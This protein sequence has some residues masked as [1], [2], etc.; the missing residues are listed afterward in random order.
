MQVTG[1]VRKRARLG[2]TLIEL[3]VVVAIIALLISILLPS[4]SKAREQARTTLCM[5]RIA[6]LNKAM[7]LYDADFAT[8]P[9]VGIG[10]ED[11]GQSKTWFGEDSMEYWA[12]NENWLFETGVMRQ[13][14]LS[15]EEDW[16]DI[17]GGRAQVR[18]GAL[19]PYTRFEELYRC[20]EFERTPNKLQNTFN[21]TRAVTGRKIYSTIIGDPEAEDELHPGPIVKTSSVYAPAAMIMLL[22]EEWQFHV[23]GNF[24]DP[25]FADLLGGYWMGAETIH[26]I[27][28]DCIGSYH[29]TKG[30]EIYID[31]N[32][33]LILENKKGSIAYYDGHVDLVRDPWWLRTLTDASIG[34]L[35][36]LLA[37]ED[38]IKVGDLILQ[39]VY[40]QRGIPFTSADL[41]ALLGV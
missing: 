9:F 31:A 14:W 1:S 16:A 35:T 11:L 23:G 26:G 17:T 27:I 36:A 29:G 7:Q 8:L 40:A 30:R 32:P 39:Q 34:D 28:G 37:D 25:G 2:F 24:N 38:V 15:P 12:E 5:S 33:G 22:D 20:P 6:Q 18:F 41:L 3:L 4:L 10:H 13:I 21:Y 19:F